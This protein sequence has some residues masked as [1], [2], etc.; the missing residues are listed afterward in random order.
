MKCNDIFYNL[1]FYLLHPSILI[2]VQHA[3][4]IFLYMTYI[5]TALF[6]P[7]VDVVCFIKYASM[8]SREEQLKLKALFAFAVY[9]S[10]V[11]AVPS[12]QL[13]QL[14]CLQ[15]LLSLC[16]VANMD[17]LYIYQ[18]KKEVIKKYSCLLTF[19]S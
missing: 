16:L 9:S 18:R 7:V 11:P 2:Y 10:S 4:Y 14:L 3:S 5:T 8:L 19:S 17:N 15:S 1:L 13:H 12:F 6:L